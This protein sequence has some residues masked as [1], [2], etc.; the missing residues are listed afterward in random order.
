MNLERVIRDY[1]QLQSSLLGAFKVS[2]PD[3]SDYSWL[4]DFPKGGSVVVGN[5]VLVFKKHG[6]G[7]KFSRETSEPYLVVD[8][9]QAVDKGYLFDEWRVL[10]FLESCGQV[11]SLE[12][13]KSEVALL[14][15]NDGPFIREGTLLSLRGGKID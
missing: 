5:D 7:L 9:H 1:I 6:A 10:Q 2:Y 8:V 15:C 14:S 12:K 13:I 4:L 11:V 3:A